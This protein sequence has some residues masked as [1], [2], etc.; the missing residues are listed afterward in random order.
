MSQRQ[1]IKTLILF[2]C[3]LILFSTIGLVI[4]WVRNTNQITKLPNTNQQTVSETFNIE[5]SQGETIFIKEPGTESKLSAAEDIATENYE[6]AINKLTQSL[7]SYPNDPEAL[8]YLNNAQIGNQKSYSLGV[9]VPIGTNTNG[10][11]EILR[12]VAQAQQEINQAGG[13]NNVPLK[14]FIANDNNSPEMA[15]Q[16]AQAFAKNSD[17]LGVVGHWS[18]DVTL[19][20]A[21]IYQAEELVV[22]SPISSSVE[23]SSF[24]DYVFRTVPSDR[25]AGDSL[26]RYMIN[27]VRKQK[28]AIFFNSES[29]YSRSLKDE[30]T[31][32]LLS[33]G[34]EIVEEFDLS[35]PDFNP[36]DSWQQAE[37]QGAAVLML[38][39]T[40]NTLPQVLDVIKINEQRLILFSGDDGYNTE[41]LEKGGADAVGM[42]L[43][44]PW[45]ISAYE[46]QPFV[47]LSQQLWGGE[48]S[49][50]TALAYDATL[51]FI[52]A[53]EKTAQPTRQSLQTT[54]AQRDFSF[55]GASGSVKFLP[56]GDRNQAVQLV[57]IKANNRS[58]FGYEF[59]LISPNLW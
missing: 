55:Q 16:L 50:R 44:I 54:L 36:N 28:A 38:A 34:G 39:V 49:W 18:S 53:L 59:E 40:T 35:Q 22:I 24:D 47:Q 19:A 26:A 17:I 12:G 13:I 43:A 37:S 9:A 29:N 14:I 33:D 1:L 4:L 21:T 10:A 23:L 56:S 30:F 31:K 42:I 6:T 46:N 25:F 45:H 51:A 57:T 3:G 20:S 27:Q 2:L 58:Q 48:I 32:S 15:T 41:I 8:I 5:I 11:K 52:K 7:Q